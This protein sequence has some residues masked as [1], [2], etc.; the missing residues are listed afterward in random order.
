MRLLAGWS[1]G[2]MIV[3]ESFPAIRERLSGLVLVAATPRFTQCDGFPHGLSP[4]EVAGM[5]EKLRRSM[6]R[7]LEG[8]TGLMFTAGEREDQPGF[9][10]LQSMLSGV[11]LPD[12]AVAQQGLAM[13]AGSICASAC[14]WS[15]CRRWC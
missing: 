8:F 7:A 11:P 15:I 2:S 12:P 5:S 13:L 1:L 10:A 9:A 14:R 6:R 4:T 3:L